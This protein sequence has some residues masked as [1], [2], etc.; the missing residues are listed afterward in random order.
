MHNNENSM[1]KEELFEKLEKNLRDFESSKIE[2]VKPNGKPLAIG[3]FE[4]CCMCFYP[5][6][7]KIHNLTNLTKKDKN[8]L[9][10]L[11]TELE[12]IKQ[13]PYVLNELEE[14]K[15]GY[16]KVVTKRIRC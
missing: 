14:T 6:Q 2:S 10:Q 15:D 3:N 5:L 11:E 4:F 12:R 7:D 13:M 16:F 9:A 8:K 1:S